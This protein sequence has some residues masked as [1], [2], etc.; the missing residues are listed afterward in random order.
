MEGVDSLEEGGEI[1]YPKKEVSEE[2][3][4]LGTAGLQEKDFKKGLPVTDTTRTH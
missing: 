1:R 2:A 4:R 3:G